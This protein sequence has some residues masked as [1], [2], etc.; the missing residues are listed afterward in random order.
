M[1]DRRRGNVDAAVTLELRHI[2]LTARHKGADLVDR[3]RPLERLVLQCLLNSRV[4]ELALRHFLVVHLLQCLVV[5]GVLVN[6]RLT[7]L[8]ECGVGELSLRDL[9]TKVLFLPAEVRLLHGNLRGLVLREGLVV[10]LRGLLTHAK[11]LHQP[12]AVKLAC[13][14]CLTEP[15]CLRRIGGLLRGHCLL[16]VLCDSAV[17][18]FGGLLLRTKRS[19]LRLAAKL[20]RLHTL[21]EGLLLCL[22][23]RGLR[24]KRGLQVL[25]HT[26]VV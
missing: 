24:G 6:G 5:E 16:V 10:L 18:L 2:D 4:V 7:L 14:H 17:V 3:Q 8:L 25:L 12:F 15:L 9:L 22:V 20:A 23:L 26:H 1:E 13:T 19:Q 21:L 11:L